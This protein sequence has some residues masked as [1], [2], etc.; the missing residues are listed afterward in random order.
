VRPIVLLGCLAS[1]LH[2]VDPQEIVRRTVELDQRNA[3]LSTNYTFLQR[4]VVRE[5]DRSGKLKSQKDETWDITPLQGS[6]YRRLVARNDQPLSP[7]E[8]Q[9]EQDKLQRS[10]EERRNETGA[11][12]ERR[13]A[14]WQAKREK[15]RAPVKELP[16]AFVFTLAGEEAIA[17][18]PV[19]VIDARPK[20]GYQPKS[21]ATAFFP[22]IKLRLWIDQGDYQGARIEMESLDTISFG[23]ILVRLEKGTRLT[24]EQTRVSDQVWL[25][26]RLSL[27]ASARLLLLKGLRREL[28]FTFS[29]YKKFQVDS[30]VVAAR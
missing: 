2:G 26:Q 22:K 11:Q 23:G 20:P 19:Y 7:E 25:P 12:R 30:H 6:P 13:L 10:I 29:D 28:E 27:D 1:L 21:T 4:Q 24:I 14:E 5:L 9:Q 3:Q 8:R 16:D 17:G 15:Q 18:R